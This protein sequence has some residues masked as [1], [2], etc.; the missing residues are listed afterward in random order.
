MIIDNPPS[1]KHNGWHCFELELQGPRSRVFYSRR[2]SLLHTWN[3]C[4]TEPPMKVFITDHHLKNCYWA[5]PPNAI[6]GNYLTR[7]S[8]SGAPTNVA[9]PPSP[10]HLLTAFNNDW[11]SHKYSNGSSISVS[12]SARKNAANSS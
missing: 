9:F 8:V 11:L 4:Y 3:T 7:I 6:A 2:N 1:Q 10:I 5:P 12:R